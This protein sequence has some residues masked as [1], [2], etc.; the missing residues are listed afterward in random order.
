MSN[1]PK[2]YQI[3]CEDEQ[4]WIYSGPETTE[5]TEC[6][7]NSGHSIKTVL[8]L[9]DPHPDYIPN[10]FYDPTTK[11]LKTDVGTSPSNIF[12]TP[13]TVRYVEKTGDET[14]NFTTIKEAT[15]TAPFG[16]LVH[17]HPGVYTELNP[18]IIPEGVSVIALGGPESVLVITQLTS[19]PLFKI[20]TKSRISGFKLLGDGSSG[21]KGIEFDGSGSPGSTSIVELCLIYNF[22]IGLHAKNGPNILIVFRC[23]IGST[24]LP[25]SKGI[26]ASD[27]SQVKSLFMQTVGHPLA[28]LGSG[29]EVTGVG[30][31]LSTLY[32]GAILCQEGFTCSNGGTFGYENV[33]MDY[34]DTAIVVK[35]GDNC[36]FKG[37]SVDIFNSVNYDIDLQV[38]DGEFFVDTADLD[39]DKI[40][41]PNNLQIDGFFY[42]NNLVFNERNKVFTGETHF[43]TFQ[44]PS[45]ISIGNGE[46]LG[47]SGISC[48]TNTNLEV[49]TWNTL[50]YIEVSDTVTLFNAF[51]SVDA[52]ASLYIGHTHKPFGMLMDINTP[53]VIN[54][55]DLVYEYWNGTEWVD[56]KIMTNSIVAP[57][58]SLDYHPFETSGKKRVRFGY[59]SSDI[60]S[61]VLDGDEKYWFRIRI[62]NTLPGIPVCQQIKLQG[63]NFN[64]SERGFKQ[65]FGDSRITQRKQLILAENMGLMS[66]EVF[67]SDSLSFNFNNNVFPSMIASEKKYIVDFPVNMDTSFPF[68]L[69]LNYFVSGGADGNIKFSVDYG[70]VF[71]GDSLYTSTAGAPT[72]SNRQVTKTILSSHSPEN[73]LDKIEI[74]LFFH[75]YKIRKD[76]GDLPKIFIR[77]RRE[78]NDV[79]DTSTHSVVCI[80][81]T[82]TY[83]SWCEGNDVTT[84]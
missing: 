35:N 76:N 42:H 34:C 3:Y 69:N 47:Y 1:I 38:G 80:N 8:E 72:T 14:G 21:S 28:K 68:K 20:P 29:M 66:Q 59:T 61:K 78:G 31:N 64:I 24:G 39:L 46:Y 56:F 51:P 37:I 30:T 50:N 48:K 74:E 55:E 32:V 45:G 17:V 60:E 25:L 71:Y 44:N 62:V 19:E 26:C 6:P 65:M 63:S 36:K 54:L 81:I 15:E 83:I 52:N 58:I 5:P 22:D 12:A 75:G 23:S 41:N 9:F 70:L 77:L 79:E 27:G 84:F 7:N 67:L 11:L 10:M 4:D 53:Q 43:G 49:G 18:I 82:S 2:Q 57:C 40:N 16:T 73:Q 33:L 13:S